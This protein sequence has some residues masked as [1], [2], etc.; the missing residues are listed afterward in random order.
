MR[1]VAAP[2]LVKLLVFALE[3]GKSMGKSRGSD[4]TGMGCQLLSVIERDRR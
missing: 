2:S 3:G 1:R 4:A